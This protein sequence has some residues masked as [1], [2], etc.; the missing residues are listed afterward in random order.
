MKII[1]LIG[2]LCCGKSTYAKALTGTMLLSC[3]QLMQTMFPG[4]CGEYHDD[5][6]TH[7]RHYLFHLAK[8][9]ADAGV[10]PV[11]DFGFW[12]PATRHEAIDALSGYELDWRYL[13]T[14]EDEWKRRIARRNADILAG[15]A[16]PSDYY[17][18]EGLLQKCVDLFIPPTPEELPG[19]MVIQA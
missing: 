11:L 9:C 16:D 4:G 7:A 19:M 12:N 15:K 6:S 18:D 10:T 14:P 8:Q 5:L 13:D 2:R 3:D 17:V 1:L